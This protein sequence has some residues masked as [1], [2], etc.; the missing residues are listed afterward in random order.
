MEE[1]I[2]LDY[3]DEE[4]VDKD[5]YKILL[6]CTNTIMFEWNAKTNIRYVSKKILEE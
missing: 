3:N 5:N 6:D 1:C 2:Y 4:Y